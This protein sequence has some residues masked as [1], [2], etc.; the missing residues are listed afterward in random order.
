MQMSPIVPIM[1]IMAIFSLLLPLS[2]LSYLLLIQDPIK[3]NAFSLFFMA[4]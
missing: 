1:S 4:L 3:V 2:V